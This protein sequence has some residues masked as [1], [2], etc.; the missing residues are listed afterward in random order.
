M[1]SADRDVRRLESQ[2]KRT[3][4]D[5]ERRLGALEAKVAKIDRR[6]DPDETRRRAY[7]P[8]A[9]RTRLG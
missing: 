1:A 4:G 5:L 2:M 3:V 8:G 7:S 6:T 9:P